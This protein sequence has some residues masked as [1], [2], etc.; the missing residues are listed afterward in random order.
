MNAFPVDYRETVCIPLPQD[1]EL[2]PASLKLLQSAAPLNVARMLAG[3]GDMF[4][5]AVGLVHAIFETQGID[6]KVRELITLR[7]T[8]LLNSPYEWQQNSEMAKM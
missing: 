6:P 8:K 3:T 7:C 5:S 1:S 2:T 4:A